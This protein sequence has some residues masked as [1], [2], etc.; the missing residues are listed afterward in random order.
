VGIEKFTPTGM[1]GLPVGMYLGGRQGVNNR[2]I[3]KL[4][5]ITDKMYSCAIVTVHCTANVRGLEGDFSY[6]KESR[7]TGK[8]GG[9]HFLLQV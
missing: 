2:L 7:L 6:K 4:Q 9:W 3:E 5:H 8:R 1:T